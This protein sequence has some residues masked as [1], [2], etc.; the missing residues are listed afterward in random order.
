MVQEGQ[1]CKTECIVKEKHKTA[2]GSFKEDT[3]RDLGI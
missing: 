1:E 3:S 2:L